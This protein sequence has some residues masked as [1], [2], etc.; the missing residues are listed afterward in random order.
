MFGGHL[1]DQDLSPTLS[2]SFPF[3]HCA[4][5]SSEKAPNLLSV[6]GTFIQACLIP[7]AATFF[8]TSLQHAWLPSPPPARRSAL[9]RMSSL[10]WKSH[11]GIPCYKPPAL[12]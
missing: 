7:Q 11:Y 8:L 6:A 4:I 3:I 10:Q 9:S 5:K 1:P 2:H 12:G